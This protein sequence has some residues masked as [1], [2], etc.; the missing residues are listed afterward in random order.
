MENVWQW[1]IFVVIVGA[2]C[3]YIGWD[4]GKMKER[5]DRLLREMRERDK[6]IAELQAEAKRRGISL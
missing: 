4:F 5:G 6:E 3:F 2:L 1:T